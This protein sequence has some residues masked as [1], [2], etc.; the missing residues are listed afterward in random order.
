MKKPILCTLSSVLCFSAFAQTTTFTE[1][2]ESLDAINSARTIGR[3]DIDAGEATLA[4]A[5]GVFQP[6]LSTATPPKVTFLISQG[7]DSFELGDV[8]GDGFDDVFFVDRGNDYFAASGVGGELTGEVDVIFDD[9]DSQRPL[10]FV[11]FDGDDDLD[12]F[13]GNTE[14]CCT[15]NR[16]YFLVNDGTPG[17]PAG[18]PARYDIGALEEGMVA[19]TFADLNGDG[20]L[21]MIT[22]TASSGTSYYLNDGSSEPFPESARSGVSTP[23]N[24][25]VDVLTADFNND[26]QLD[27]FVTTSSFSVGASLFLNS[28]NAEA[29]FAPGALPDFSTNTDA[30][31]RAVADMNADGFLDIVGNDRFADGVAILFNTGT[32]DVFGPAFVVTNLGDF[33][34]SGVIDIDRNGLPDLVARNYDPARVYLNQ[35]GGSFSTSSFVEVF[36]SSGN[37]ARVRDINR[38]GIEDIAFSVNN[39]NQLELYLGEEGRSPFAAGGTTFAFGDAGAF[40]SSIA[41]ADL[42]NDGDEDI[43]EGANGLN[44]VYVNNNGNYASAFPITDDADVTQSVVVGDL[45]DDGFPD[46]VAANDGINRWYPNDLGDGP[47]LRASGGIAIG[48]AVTDSLDVTIVDANDD[49]RPDIVFANDG[50]NTL[51]LNA[52]GAEPFSAATVA[53]EL[54]QDAQRSN[55]VVGADVTGDGRI[56]LMFANDGG[57]VWLANE[58]TGAGFSATSVEQALGADETVSADLVAVDLNFDGTDDVLLAKP[59]GACRWFEG[60]G[61]ADGFDANGSGTVFGDNCSGALHVAAKVVGAG[62]V[63]VIAASDTPLYYRVLA[64]L[65]VSAASGF[66]VT[67][68][69]APLRDLVFLANADILAANFFSAN[70][71]YRRSTGGFDAQPGPGL[72]SLFGNR[73]QSQPLG[74]SA[75]P[76]TTATISVETTQ[77]ANT[78]IEW[79]V[80]NDGV[81]FVVAQPNTV[82]TFET[83][84]N[85]VIWAADMTSLST[86]VTPSIQKVIAEINPVDDDGDSV[87]DVSDNCTATSNPLQLDSDGDG[88]GNAC[89]A[90]LNNDGIV[91]VQDLGILR[92]VFFSTVPSAADLNSDGVVNA[93]DLGLMRQMFFQPPG[94]SAL[95]P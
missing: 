4:P 71:V 75:D 17:F 67:D 10:K 44:R 39:Q 1:N 47:F 93:T 30:G 42:D 25:V 33:T 85:A 18:T 57:D 6:P 76:V 13:I 49:G 73:I 7:F 52:G 56:D 89:D 37:D 40:T 74:V 55:A 50:I 45:N 72:F 61:G 15:N 3:V 41:A 87:A 21:D 58:G 92:A 51:Y 59:D 2:F 34:F 95:V 80:S 43:V 23:S 12:I 90:D 83:P 32:P 48:S 22:H 66:A 20:R 16:S 78:S 91:N 46:V 35:G 9:F 38:D 84:G 82:V 24:N 36:S 63:E 27:L 5:A 26:G 53:I 31:F 14:T 11:D 88:Y 65:G 60:S 94:P 28:G 86:A 19:A 29:P 79:S 81:N 70:A 69:V 8:T 77:P 62:E 54:G 68:D 64:S